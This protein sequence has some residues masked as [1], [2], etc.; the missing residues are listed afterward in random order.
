MMVHTSGFELIDNVR[1]RSDE[2]DEG[3][4]ISVFP[5]GVLAPASWTVI[6]LIHLSSYYR[7]LDEYTYAFLP[8]VSKDSSGIQFK[9]QTLTLSRTN[10]GR[11]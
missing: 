9:V 1:S 8:C 10:P 3:S 5:E 7:S 2:F 4:G 6:V 11:V